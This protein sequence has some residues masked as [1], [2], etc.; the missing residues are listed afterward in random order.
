MSTRTS[1]TGLTCNAKLWNRLQKLS[2]GDSH[3]CFLIGGSKCILLY[4][5]VFEAELFEYQAGLEPAMEQKMILISSSSS[6][7]WDFRCTL[8]H[9]VFISSTETKPR[10]WCILGKYC[11]NWVTFLVPEKS[12]TMFLNRFFKLCVAYFAILSGGWVVIFIKYF[13]FL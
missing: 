2:K 12:F 11:V 3:C 10:A 4:Y 9:A 13:L 6:L 8:L 1:F 7:C 5:F